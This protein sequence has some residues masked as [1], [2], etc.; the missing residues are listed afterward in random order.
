[1][2][3]SERLKVE[4]KALFETDAASFVDKKGVDEIFEDLR[5]LMHEGTPYGRCPA[6][7]SGG[8]QT[9]DHA[10]LCQGRGWVS[11]GKKKLFDEAWGGI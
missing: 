10:S 8:S 2:R 7:D 11:L 5:R 6:C 9:K 1:M 3:L 4:T